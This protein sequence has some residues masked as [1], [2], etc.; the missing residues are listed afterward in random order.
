M[1]LWNVPHSDTTRR[2][3]IHIHGFQNVILQCPSVSKISIFLCI[4][5]VYY[6]RVITCRRKQKSKFSVLS[7]SA[8]FHISLSFSSHLYLHTFH[9]F[10]T[11]PSL[12]FFPF[13]HLLFSCFH[14]IFLQHYLLLQL[15]VHHRDTNID[16]VIRV[17]HG[18]LISQCYERDLTHIFEC[19][20]SDKVKHEHYTSTISHLMEE[21]E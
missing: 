10:L 6:Y 14:F 16:N 3:G 9:L 19:S 13:L 11:F 12:L 2:Y 5:G 21:T 18:V 7:S 15:S 4:Y 17:M 20:G 1:E 8:F